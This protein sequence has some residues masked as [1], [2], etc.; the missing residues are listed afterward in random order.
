MWGKFHA[1][2]VFI[3]CSELR[4]LNCYAQITEEDFR[5]TDQKFTVEVELVDFSNDEKAA[6]PD[7]VDVDSI[8]GLATLT[9][10][11][12]ADGGRQ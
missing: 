5:D 11:L 3:S 7:E 4:R 6:F 10:R 12:R 2:V 8:T 1:F 9:L